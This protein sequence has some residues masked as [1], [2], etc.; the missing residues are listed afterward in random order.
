MAELVTYAEPTVWYEEVPRSVESHV[1][2]G[3][4]LLIFGLGGF[5]IWAFM[6]PLA[7]AVISQGSFVATGSNKIVQHLEGGIIKAILVEEGENVVA[8]QPIVLLDETSALA[9]QRELFLRQVRL[10]AME[11][12]ILAEFDR[13]DTLIYPPRLEELRADFNVAAMLD[14]QQIVFNAATQQLRNDINLLTQSIEA[15]KDRS[16]GYEKQLIAT[17]AQLEI[18][19][20]DSAAKEVLLEKGLVRKTEYNT[21]RRALAEAIGE[22]GRL[23]A[24]VDETASLSQ[25]YESQITQTIADRQSAALDELQAV[26]SELESVREQARRAESVLTRTEIVAPVS[27][28]VIRLHYHT[29]GGVVESGKAILEILPTGE[30]LIIEVQIPRTEIDVVRKGQAATVSLT[31]LNQRTTPT[32]Q[33]EVFYV[34]ADAILDRSQELPQEIYVARIS[35]PPSELD[36]VRGFNPT[37][38]MPAQIMIKTQDRTFVQ[39]LIKPVTDSMTRAFREQ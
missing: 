34:S 20:E 7:A 39:Y 32:L 25:R 19:E 9:T 1:R 24:Q 26:Q 18:L 14:G 36:R 15:L 23:E 13:K 21:L 27:G 30:P 37:P 38:G 17:R 28:T 31:A 8:G 5:G 10:E 3:M 2:W 4:F 33:G 29:P 22:I 35:V 11:T 16:S 12:R 6:A